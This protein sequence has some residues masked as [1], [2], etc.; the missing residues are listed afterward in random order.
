[1]RFFRAIG[2]RIEAL[3]L[4]YEEMFIASQADHS[5]NRIKTGAYLSRIASTVSRISGES[6]IR[7][8][9][10]CEEID[11]PVDQAARLG[12]P[13]SEFLTNA[14]EHAFEGRESGLVNVR[15][16]ELSGGGVRLSVEDDGIGLPEGIDWPFDS[17]SV[18]SQTDQAETKEGK[19]DTTG[20]GGHSGVGGSIVVALTEMLGATLDVTRA[21][22]GTTISVDLEAAG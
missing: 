8:N 6:A 21:L 22:K 4:L 19:L 15:F 13:L 17:R 20:H 16:R 12:L 7:V 2:R 5:W 3:A 11:L 18:Q 14:L 1:M 10:D 9:V